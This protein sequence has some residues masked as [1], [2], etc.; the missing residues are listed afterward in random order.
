M[1]IEQIENIDCIISYIV[2]F[3]IIIC[4]VLSINNTLKN[5]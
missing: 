1:S 3:Q 2:K 5:I 4:F